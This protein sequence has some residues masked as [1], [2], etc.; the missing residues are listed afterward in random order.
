MDG[1]PCWKI[2]STPK[3]SRSSQYTRSMT[4][5]R[6]DNYAW[7]RIDSYVKDDVVRRLEY[8]KIENIQGVWTARETKMTDL[9][10]G[11]I[12]RLMLDKVEYNL[13]LKDEDFSIQALRR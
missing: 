2:Q 5:I 4:W 9:R 13:P 1:A 6:K 12:T 3:Q 10:R 7:A 11:S 8:A